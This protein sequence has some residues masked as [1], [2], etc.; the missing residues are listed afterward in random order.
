VLGQHPGDRLDLAATRQRTRSRDQR[1]PV[2]DHRGVLHEAAVGERVVR[3]QL[4]HGQAEV[5]DERGAVGGVLGTR[6][7]QTDRHLRRG[8]AQRGCERGRDVTREREHVAHRRRARR[9]S[10][11]AAHRLEHHPRLADD[12]CTSRESILSSTV[13]QARCRVG[14]LQRRLSRDPLRGGIVIHPAA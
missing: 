13:L 14:G 12:R 5:V 11:P 3:G 9:R 1:D 10:T 2:R 8:R 6:A 4:K 7:R